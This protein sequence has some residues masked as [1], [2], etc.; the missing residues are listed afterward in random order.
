MMNKKIL[1]VGVEGAIGSALFQYLNKQSCYQVFGTTHHQKN[2]SHDSNCLYLDLSENTL[3]L[4]YQDFDLVYLCAGISNMKYCEENPEISMKINVEGIKKVID[5]FYS[6]RTKFVFLSSSQVFS[7][8]KKNLSNVENCDPQNVYGVQKLL[9]EE[10]LKTKTNHYSIVRLSKVLHKGL[11]LIQNW[12]LQLKRGEY[13]E[14]FYDVNM[15]PISLDYVVSLLELIGLDPNSEIYQLSGIND[16]SYF[17]FAQMYASFMGAELSLVKPISFKDKNI[18][19]NFISQFTS[20]DLNNI[21]KK[22]WPMPNDYRD[23][24]QILV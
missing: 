16:I 18:E 19:N 7:G 24:L 22:Q 14:A 10:Y 4:N 9:I 17:N 11:A 8:I 2:L 3:K 15:A 5:F 23:L 6:T 12:R 20:L 13:I 21:M 1:I